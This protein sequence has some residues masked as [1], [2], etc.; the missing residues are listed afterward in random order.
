MDKLLVMTEERYNALYKEK[1]GNYEWEGADLVRK[2]MTEVGPITLSR[3]AE[4][5]LYEE[6]TG[7]KSLVSEFLYDRRYGRAK[8]FSK[9]LL[10]HI[11]GEIGQD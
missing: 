10:A 7:S 5:W 6:W 8:G 1:G 3:L 2:A 4:D 11:R 9:Y